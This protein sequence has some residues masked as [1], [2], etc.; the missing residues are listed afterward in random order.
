MDNKV[1]THRAIRPSVRQE[2][3]V[4]SAR[5]FSCRE[6]NSAGHIRID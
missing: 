5:H 2:L 4:E 6:V 3:E 1:F